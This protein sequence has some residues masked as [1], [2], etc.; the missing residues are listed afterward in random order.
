MRSGDTLHSAVDTPQLLLC[1]VRTELIR[2]TR[3]GVR[4][5]RPP[6]TLPASPVVVCHDPLPKGRAVE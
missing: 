4:S 1:D 3:S 6:S 2:A 5:E